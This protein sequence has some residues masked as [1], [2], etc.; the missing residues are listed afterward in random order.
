MSQWSIDPKLSQRRLATL[1]RLL[2][3]EATLIGKQG[4]TASVRPGELDANEMRQWARQCSNL[5]NAPASA[6]KAIEQM[7][8]EELLS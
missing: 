6:P 1:V 4:R 7:S 3:A 2:E 5:L 8:D